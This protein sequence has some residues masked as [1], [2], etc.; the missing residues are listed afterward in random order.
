MIGLKMFDFCNIFDS[1]Y[2]YLPSMSFA[3]IKLLNQCEN[4]VEGGNSMRNKGSSLGTILLGTAVAALVG[5]ALYAYFDDDTR[6][7]VQGVVTREKVKLYVK[8]QL[9]GSDKLVDLVDDLS[10]SEVNT[11]VKLASKSMETGNR[12]SDSFNQIAN[13]AKDAAS[14]AGHKV[15]DMFNN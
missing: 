3:I 14:D 6:E 12:V 2:E 11:L 4:T 13:R 10:D 15:Q 9:N 5:V 7:R 1:A 8:H